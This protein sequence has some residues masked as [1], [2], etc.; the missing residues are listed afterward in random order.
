MALTLHGKGGSPVSG[1]K[2]EDVDYWVAP[3]W[4]RLKRGVDLY[5]AHVI[6]EI[7]MDTTCLN[8]TGMSR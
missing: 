3:M 8:P 4:E 6:E 5:F 2:K 1:L 7:L